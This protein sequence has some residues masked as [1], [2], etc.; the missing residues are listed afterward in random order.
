MLYVYGIVDANHFDTIEGEGHEAGDI[1]PIP[2][3]ELAAAISALSTHAIEATPQN[4]WRHERVLEHLMQDHAVLPLRFGTICRDTE[5]LKEYLLCSVDGHRNDL[6]HVRGKVEMALRIAENDRRVELSGGYL[7]GASIP[8]TDLQGGG[9]VAINAV[10]DH[11]PAG[12]GA[13]YLRATMQRLRGDMA[14]ED[15]AKRLELLLRRDLATVLKDAVCAPP[16]DGSADYRVSCLV[17]RCRI[18]AFTETLDRFRA[19]HPQ[20]DISCTGPWA[21]YSFVAAPQIFGRAS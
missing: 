16:A 13:A 14:R 20:F 1:A 5:A 18:A 7:K 10:N 8:I 17:E 12:R 9:A 11:E 2:C 4:V 3:G 15:S 21:P 19:D 6:E